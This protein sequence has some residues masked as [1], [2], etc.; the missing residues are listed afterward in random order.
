MSASS[1]GKRGGARTIVAFM[2]SRHTLF[3]YGF[4]K[5]ER[6]DIDPTELRGLKQFA[7]YLLGL[8]NRD[9]AELISNEEL[10]EVK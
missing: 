2:S 8:E 4:L 5:N 6:A 3:M 9:I 7:G 1:R 10:F